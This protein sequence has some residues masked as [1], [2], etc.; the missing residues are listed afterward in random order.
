MGT[1]LI[2][3]ASSFASTVTTIS[4]FLDPHLVLVLLDFL[5][6]QDDADKE[7]DEV[8][9]ELIAKTNMV[10]Y[11]LEVHASVFPGE[12]PPADLVGSRETVVGQLK[13]LKEMEES[14][15]YNRDGVLEVEDVTVE[16]VD[17][18]RDYAKCLYECSRYEAAAE[19][20]GHYLKFA[21]EGDV[22]PALWGKLASEILTANNWSVAYDDLLALKDLLD[23]PTSGRRDRRRNN[24]NS[25]VGGSS[26]EAAVLKLQERTWLIHFSLFVFFNHP[27]GRDGIIDFLFEDEYLNTI[28]TSCPHILRY[29]TTAVV[30]NKRR[31]N[32]LKSLVSVLE[33][34]RYSYSDPITEFVYSLYVEFDFD[35]AREKLNACKSVLA[36]DFFLVACQEDFMTNARLFIF[37]TFCRVHQQI[38]LS[39]L[40]SKLDMDRDEAEKWIVSLVRNAG[41]D[42]KI[43]SAAD[44]VVMGN[45]YPSIY[46]QIIEK[47]KSLS[48]RTSVLAN[49]CSRIQE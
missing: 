28:Q 41:I 5:A 20:L 30:T 16:A 19:Y 6:K 8:R 13:A 36:S 1:S 44:L 11:A 37:E 39:V 40:A 15:R 22:L 18:L 31:R 3:S 34:E 4:P 17:A 33:Q 43:D 24:Q 42:A 26:N 46:A 23:P 7:I 48:L 2:M 49:N 9:Y 35:A 38:D 47:T 25:G 32:V 29:L 45:Q 14:G 10:D 21:S 27:D 12:D